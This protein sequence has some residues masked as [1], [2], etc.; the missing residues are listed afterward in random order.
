MAVVWA[1]GFGSLTHC[2]LM[3]A[4]PPVWGRVGGPEW[5]SYSRLGVSGERAEGCAC[6]C[7]F[8]FGGGCVYTAFGTGE[9][10]ARSDRSQIARVNSSQCSLAAAPG[11]SAT[12]WH[13]PFQCGPAC[14]HA[15]RARARVSPR[16]VAPKFAASR[17]SPWRST[18]RMQVGTSAGLGA[19]RAAWL[20][21]LLLARAAPAHTPKTP[22]SRLLSAC[23]APGAQRQRYL[24]T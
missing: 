12:S 3:S 4:P 9:P 21:L 19:M 23:G 20:L 14:Q 11:H 1:A 7:V 5:A 10:L 18:P 6:L 16:A 24:I 8:V 2:T 15:A 13:A 22:V 17:P